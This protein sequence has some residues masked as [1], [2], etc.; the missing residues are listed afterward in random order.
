MEEIWKDV[1]GFEGMY[2]ISNHGRLKSFLRIKTG[3][4]M[5]QTN[6]KGDYFRIVLNQKKSTYIHHLVAFHFI[7]DRPKG[8]HIDH[9]DGNKQNNRVDNL[10]Y[11][12]MIHHKLKTIKENPNSLKGM[13]HYNKYIRPKTVLQITMDG[14]I[15][16]EFPSCLEAA[17]QTGVCSR[18]ISQVAGK[19]EYR[20]GL[21]R[22]QAGGF[23]WK[24]KEDML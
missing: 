17:R 15:I 5:S 24:Y 10:Q 4:I 23:I 1:K 21:T 14:N 16:G 22:N 2:Q 12:T 9:I 7:G 11:I 6:K 8:Y 19:D 13:I 3:H 20:P 18:N